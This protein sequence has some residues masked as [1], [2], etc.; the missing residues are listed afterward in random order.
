MNTSTLENT[1]WRDDF[2]VMN[3][4][5]ITIPLQSLLFYVK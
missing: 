2:L 1:S 4:H 5:N 3:C